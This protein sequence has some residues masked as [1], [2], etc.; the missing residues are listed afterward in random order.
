MPQPRAV[1][2]GAGVGGLTA[3]VAL[4]R[5]RW[6]VTVLERAR[7]LEP[8]GAGIAVAPNAQRALDVLGLGDAVRAR[9]AFSGS[10]GLRTPRG[11]WISRTTGEAAAARFGGP[12]VLTRRAE[13][14]DLLLGALPEGTVRTGTTVTHVE[15]GAAGGAPARVTSERGTVEA[16]LVV[17][18]DG[19]HSP[20]RAALFPDHPGPDYAG[21]TAWRFVA[22]APATGYEPHETWGRGTLWGT[23]PL[24]GSRVY[25][26]ATAVVPPGG[27]A[28]DDEL[29]EL[30]RR[31]GD[32]H[33]PVPQLLDAVAADAVLRDDV[34]DMPTPLPAFHRGRVALLGDAAHPMT[35]NLGQGGCQA[36]E[37]AVVLA[38]L[39]TAEGELAAYTERRLPRTTLVARR[40]RRVAALTAWRSRPAVAARALMFAATGLLGPAAALRALDGIADWRPPGAY[41]RTG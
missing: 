15:P 8:V 33:A 26:Y 29:A 34:H 38:H 10:G 17:A 9:A 14:V 39:A 7:V 22:D 21:L 3:A 12:V 24:A 23:T 41:Q 28:P 5:R 40:S 6:R 30:R 25:C 1:V 19:V 27:R 16:E 35:P 36:V 13:L 20:T 11:R 18:A 4:W 2:V 37:D 31:F 32:W